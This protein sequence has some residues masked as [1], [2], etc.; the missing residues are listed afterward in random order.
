VIAGPPLFV[1]GVPLVGLQ[2]R[3]WGPFG[4]STTLSNSDAAA[5]PG[6]AGGTAKGD[7]GNWLLV[8]AAMAISA[9]LSGFY[10]INEYA[11]GTGAVVASAERGAERFDASF[12]ELVAARYRTLGLAADTMLQSR[13]TVQAFARGDREALGAIIEPFFQSL[14]R[15]HNIAQ[16]NFWTAPAAM[17]YRAGSPNEFGMDLSR[18]RRSIV[19]A[20]ERRQRILAVETGLGGFVALRAIVPVVHDGNFVGSLEFVSNFNIPLERASAI[21]GMAWAYSINKDVAERTER[22]PQ[23]SNDVRQG[24]DIYIA[25]SDV[26][27]AHLMRQIQFNPRSGDSQLLAQAGRNVLVKTFLVTNFSGVPTITIATVLDVTEQFAAILRAVLIKCGVLFV[28][29]ALVGSLVAISFRKSG[30]SFVGALGRQRRELAE[31]TAMAEAAMAKLKQVDLIKRGFFNNLVT[32]IAEPLQAVSGHLAA[33]APKANDAGDKALVEALAFPQAEMA[34]LS[35]LVD[36]FHQVELFRQGLV[37]TEAPL[38]ALAELVSCSI[39][40]DL[41]AYRRLP[42]LAI[43]MAVPAGLPRAR[44]DG[45]LLR[46]AIGSLVGFAAQRSGQGEVRFSA[47]QDAQGWLVLRMTGTAFFGPAA[48]SEMLLDEAGQFLAQLAEDSHVAARANAL[49]GVVLARMIVEFYGGTLG[50]AGPEAPGFV[51]RLPAAG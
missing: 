10:G 3:E 6:R 22:P 15:D 49:I 37:K 44:V 7:K 48:P 30:A 31:R 23:P 24:D 51:I 43:A 27:T 1:V 2:P 26:A 35:R 32:A 29:M 11:S 19:A 41:A 9:L 36:D 16:L 47:E 38:A 45:D 46:R 42:N 33:L 40:E 4:M 21:S 25:F 5:A 18:F 17:F 12:Q 39:D 20:N 28:L 14:Q 34:R 50:V 8:L 13:V